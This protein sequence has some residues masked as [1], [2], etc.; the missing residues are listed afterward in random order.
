MSEKENLESS[1]N[2][3]LA[4]G[5]TQGIKLDE[6]QVLLNED[7]KQPISTNDLD[8]QLKKL[9]DVKQHVTYTDSAYY[10]LTSGGRDLADA[11]EENGRL[12]GLKI[13]RRW[14]LA[15]LLLLIAAIGWV[16]FQLEGQDL[17][18]MMDLLLST[19]PGR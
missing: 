19:L 14:L 1:N 5:R 6:L 9:K 18:L 2:I 7:F 3:I 15:I 17:R 16:C 10:L 4:L 12:E 13:W 8:A 11:L